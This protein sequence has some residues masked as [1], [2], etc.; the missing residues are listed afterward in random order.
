MDRQGDDERPIIRASDISRYVFCRRA[1]WYDRQGIA[2]ANVDAMRRGQRIHLHH[3]VLV[4]AVQVLA[5][6]AALLVI[7]GVFLAAIYFLQM[8]AGAGG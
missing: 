6:L 2:S 7:T 4:R 8:A 5:I 1:W 3:G